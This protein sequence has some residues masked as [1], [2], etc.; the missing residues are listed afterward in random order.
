MPQCAQM[1][2]RHLVCCLWNS[3]LRTVERVGAVTQSNT[4]HW[5]HSERDGV[6][7]YRHL[8]CLLNR[9]FRRRSKKTS[10][11]RVTGPYERNPPVTGEF[12]S[13]RASN[14]ENVSIWWRHHEKWLQ[15]IRNYPI[16]QRHK[17][18]MYRIRSH[19]AMYS[20]LLHI[21]HCLSKTNSISCLHVVLAS[22]VLYFA[23]NLYVNTYS[24]NARIWLLILKTVCHRM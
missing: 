21:K 13:Q 8:D 19:F 20:V 24:I 9:L 10:K 6:S 15:C 12:P 17:H 16:S 2:F 4:L 7:N 22:V 14:A 1:I 23:Q 18:N 11:L 5:Q 3:N